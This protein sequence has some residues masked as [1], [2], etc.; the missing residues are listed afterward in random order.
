MRTLAL[1]AVLFA[2]CTCRDRR[3]I[4]PDGDVDAD[5]DG[6][7]DSDSDSDTNFDA[8]PCNGHIGD[9]YPSE[10]AGHCRYDA[11]PD[12]GYTSCDDVSW[13]NDPPSSGMHCPD[14][15]TTWGEHSEVVDR[16]NWVHNL[17][18]GWI[19]LLHNCGDVPCDADLDIMRQILA[20]APREPDGDSRM[21]MT[22]DPLLQTKF[23]A[24]AWTWAW[25]GDA[26]DLETLRC[27]VQW[28]YGNGREGAGMPDG[29]L[30]LDAAPTPDAAADAGRDAARGR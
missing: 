20:E 16:C 3:T 15:E 29:G 9:Y 23:A 10:G 11:G 14:W 26:V 22:P 2:A 21:L 17:E 28:H 30:V 8:G 4:V 25:E 27:F 6:D 19:V 1:L 24:V 5:V 7:V 12:S 13:K 18:H